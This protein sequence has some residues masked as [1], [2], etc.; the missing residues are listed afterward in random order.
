VISETRRNC[1]KADRQGA[2]GAEASQLKEAINIKR[3]TQSGT[4]ASR[5][6]EKEVKAQ[7]HARP[8]NRV[9]SRASSSDQQRRGQQAKLNPLLPPRL[10]LR[11]MQKEY[12]QLT[13]TL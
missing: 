9:S 8:E 1:G 11:E 12:N 13:I 4:T 7:R 2:A 3:R 10:A 5:R 6:L